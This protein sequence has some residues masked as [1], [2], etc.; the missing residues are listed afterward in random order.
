[1]FLSSASL[2]ALGMELQDM[3]V[4]VVHYTKVLA[5]WEMVAKSRPSRIAAFNVLGSH[6]Y[7]AMQKCPISSVVL[8]KLN[9]TVSDPWPHKK[10]GK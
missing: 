7:L 8:S 4:Q 5:K 10:P 6:L 9:H 3:M 2:E 1:M